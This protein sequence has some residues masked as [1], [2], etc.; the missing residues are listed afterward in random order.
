M[1]GPEGDAGIIPRFCQ[2]LIAQINGSNDVKVNVEMSFFEIY[3]EKIHDLLGQSSLRD[4]ATG[5]KSSLKVREHPT[6]GPYVEGLS[7]HGVTLP[8]L[9]HELM[10]SNDKRR[11]T[12][13]TGMNDTSSRSHSVFSLLLTKTTTEVI[14]GER[15]EHTVVSK[16]NLVDLAGSERHGQAK[17]TGDRLCPK[18]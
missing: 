5:K 17:T 6:Q 16:I 9:S 13:A 4:K 14:D 15:H 1:I 18:R 7:A 12:A 2:D 10:S 11:V 8:T 3:N